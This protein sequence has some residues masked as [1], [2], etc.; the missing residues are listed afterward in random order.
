MYLLKDRKEGLWH[1]EKRND[2]Q[3]NQ[4]AGEKFIPRQQAMPKAT[5]LSMTNLSLHKFH[6]RTVCLC[7]I[8][9]AGDSLATVKQHKLGMTVQLYSQV[10]KF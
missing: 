6:G 2:E 4:L 7:R 1:E 10:Q 9:I 3:R 5:R 8:I